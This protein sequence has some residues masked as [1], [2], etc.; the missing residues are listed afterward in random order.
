MKILSAFD[1][2]LYGV[3]ERVRPTLERLPNY[4]KEN[5][6]EI[7]LRANLPVS[8]TVSGESLYLT[9]DA[10][11]SCMSSNLVH[12]DK[13][14]IE[15]SYRLI[16]GNS[17]FAHSNELKSGFVI[18]RNGHRAGICGT[19]DGENPPHSISSINIR[20]ARQVLGCASA[21]ATRYRNGGILIAGPPG[22]GKTTILRDLI[23]ILSTKHGKRITVVDSR[24]E[25]SGSFLGESH[26]DLGPNTDIIISPDK[27]LGTDIAIRTMFP[28]MVAFDEVG[29]KPELKSLKDSFNCGVDIIT[30]AHI[31]YK[32]DLVK[33]DITRE[34]I[35][36]GIT[37][38]IVLLPPMLSEEIEFLTSEDLLL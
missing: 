15:E 33:R 17:V 6:Q 2:S 35:M 8:V 20:I 29:T 1:S 28:D 19:F 14:D 24:G 36:G 27:A 32:E 9:E 13:E 30:T 26:N 5:I 22:S 10:S 3:C 12:T 18:M 4:I 11:V 16:C 37:P 25:L 38:L 34:L 23:R 31:H 21:V 7:R